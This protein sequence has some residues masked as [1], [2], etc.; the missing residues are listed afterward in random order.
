MVRD[1]ERI[2]QVESA[3]DFAPLARRLV[4]AILL[5][6]IKDARNCETIKEQIAALS[7]IRSDDAKFYAALVGLEKVWPPQQE[8]LA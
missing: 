2:S 4:C 6:A 3:I 1:A 7:W 8:E 5:Q